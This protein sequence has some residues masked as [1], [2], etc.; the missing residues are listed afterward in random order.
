MSFTYMMKVIPNDMNKFT[1]IILSVLITRIIILL[2]LHVLEF[3]L[4]V[5]LGFHFCLYLIMA[6]IQKSKYH[7][8]NL[9]ERKRSNEITPK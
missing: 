8:V 7:Y 5:Y 3:C 2:I 4:K 1:S 6:H 9:P